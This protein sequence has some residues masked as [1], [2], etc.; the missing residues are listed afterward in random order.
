M[1]KLWR[2][3]SVGIGAVALAAGP[4]MTSAQA[5]AA[6]A[7][8]VG[9]HVHETFG[10]FYVGAPSLGIDDPVVEAVNGRTFNIQPVTGG[11]EFQFTADLSK[12]MAAANNGVDVVIHVC[13]G[14][15][16]V[17]W[18]EVPGPATTLYESQKFPNMFLSGDNH[19]D[20]FEIQPKHANGWEQQFSVG[21]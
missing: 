11:E 4:V 8:V 15:S 7:S 12:C 17:V 21:S 9:S 10:S 1:R 6:S 19:G 14:G 18:K 20:Q 5:G 3:A 2:L 13:N 16:G